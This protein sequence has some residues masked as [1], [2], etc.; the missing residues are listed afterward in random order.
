MEIF[1][2]R[3]ERLH[4]VLRYCGLNAMKP[5]FKY[6]LLGF[7]LVALAA[8]SYFFLAGRGDKLQKYIPD[9][10]ALVVKIDPKSILNG[11]DLEALKKTE[12]FEEAVADM[13]DESEPLPV[14]LS[15]A[16]SNPKE[17]GINWLKPSYVFMRAEKGITYT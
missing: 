16:M 6:S 14:L 17:T 12:S 1:T 4:S 9:N 2:R 5:I 10:A 11:L 15:Q 8:G 3:C 7:G 13:K